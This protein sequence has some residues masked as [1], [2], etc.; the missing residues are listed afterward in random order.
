MVQQ[1]ER[2]FAVMG[3]NSLSLDFDGQVPREKTTYLPN[4]ALSG[5]WGSAEHVTMTSAGICT[6]WS[7][8]LGGVAMFQGIGGHMAKECNVSSDRIFCF[9]NSYRRGIKLSQAE[10][11]CKNARRFHTVA[12]LHIPFP[13]H[14]V[15]VCT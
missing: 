2:L 7:C 12:L 1:M 14:R 11:K 4:H 3:S 15:V 13:C 6:P 10:E 8:S 9:S 5:D